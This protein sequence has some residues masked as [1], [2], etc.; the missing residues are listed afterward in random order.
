MLAGIRQLPRVTCPE[1][2]GAFYAFPSIEDYLGRR[3]EGIEVPDA[4]AFARLFLQERLV[5]TVTGDAFG[6]PGHIRLTYCTSEADIVE[7]LGRLGSFL[8]ALD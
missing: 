4:T 2:R 8:D 1:P 7:G 6:A 5:A 3:F